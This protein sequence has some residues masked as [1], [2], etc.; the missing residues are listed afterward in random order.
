MVYIVIGNEFILCVYYILQEDI[1]M[2]QN[3]VLINLSGM[4]PLDS[5]ADSEA[6][7]IQSRLTAGRD[8]FRT[9]VN[10]V[11]NSVMKI[12]ALDLALHDNSEKISDIS[13]EIRGISQTVVEASTVTG[14]SMSEVVKV[15]EGFTESISHVS[16]AAGE[17]MDE[18]G[19][20]SKELMSIVNESQNTIDASNDMKKDMQQLLEVLKN[21]NEVIRGINSISAQTNM[22]A[23]N[24]SIEAA[25]AGE[26]GR[27]FAVVAEQIR[28]LADE[29]KQLIGNMD[30]FVSKIEDASRM[31]S[32][33]L[34]KT[35]AEL[36]VMQENLNKVLE[37][38]AK[39]EQNVTNINDSITTIAATS[40]EIFSTITNVHDQMDRLKD[41]CALLNEQSANLGDVSM[42]LRKSMEPVSSIEKELDDS[43]QMMGDM[44]QDVF[45]VL[46]NQLFINTVQNAIIAHQNWLKTLETIVNSRDILPLQTDDTKCA[47]GHFYY[48]INPRNSM[49]TGVWNGLAEKHRRFHSHGKSAIEAIRRQDYGKADAEYKEAVKLSTELIDDFKRIIDAAKILES[50]NK[51]VFMA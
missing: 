43:A 24:A 28:N 25:R 5:K 8:K 36:G 11:F 1:R 23:L 39:N 15:H 34:D 46:D 4:L 17:I 21:M 19:V 49:I 44:V 10:G 3:K 30:E 48:A 26:A 22:L 27:G 18:M 33:S 50:G 13:E 38:Y 29:T 35:V 6:V 41:E 42:S 7:H 20:S 14:E 32:A 9:I 40:E 31:S 51:S 12:S 37:N 2:R 45:Y 47:F 16:A